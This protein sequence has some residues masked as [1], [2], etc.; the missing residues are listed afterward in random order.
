MDQH[1]AVYM[2]PGP[3]HT[4]L[5][6]PLLAR[7]IE[8]MGLKYMWHHPQSI[9]PVAIEGKDGPKLCSFCFGMRTKMEKE[10]KGTLKPNNKWFKFLLLMHQ[11]VENG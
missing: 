9:G 4:A 2:Y 10:G 8:K 11:K 7:S 1:A 3:I 5:S 6:H